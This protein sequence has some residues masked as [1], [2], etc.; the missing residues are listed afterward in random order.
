MSWY[1]NGAA[2][3]G[4]A[5]ATSQNLA[6]GLAILLAGVRSMTP[7]RSVWVAVNIYLVHHSIGFISVKNFCHR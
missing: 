5:L 3:N 6:T 4:D 2:I 1:Q 7:V